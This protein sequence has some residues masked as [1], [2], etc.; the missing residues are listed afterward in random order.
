MGVADE[1]LPAVGHAQRAVDEELDHRAVHLGCDRA[2]LVQVQLARQ[3]HLREARVLQEARLGRRAD[4]GLRARVQL[5][6][7][8]V[9]LEQPHVLHDQRVDAGRVQLPGQ[10]P[11]GLELV[12][13][14]DGVQR[15]EHARVEAVRV[16]AQALDLGHRVGRLVARA[17]AG[18]ADVDRVRP[19]VHRLDADVGVAGGGEELELG[20]Q[21]HA[22]PRQAAA[23]RRRAPALSKEARSAA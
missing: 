18:A 3:H 17:E 11:R 2:D 4:V 1:A 9:E 15:H 13:A 22:G 20:A 8:Q 6:W 5:Q 23:A 19:V 7:R 21:R 10:A 12:V 14:Q 16:A